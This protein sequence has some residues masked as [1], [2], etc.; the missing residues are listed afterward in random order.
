M[1]FVWI[2]LF[3]VLFLSACHS[4]VPDGTAD[5]QSGEENVQSSTF[6]S[7][8]KEAVAHKTVEE[9]SAFLEE[10]LKGFDHNYVWKVMD[11]YYDEVSKKSYPCKWIFA[12]NDLGEWVDIV[13][14]QESEEIA[15]NICFGE[16]Y[17]GPCIS[18]WR[19]NEQMTYN[20]KLRFP[21]YYVGGEAE[22]YESTNHE[23]YAVITGQMF[24]MHDFNNG[25]SSFYWDGQ[26]KTMG[27]RPNPTEMPS[28]PIEEDGY[29]TYTPA[30]SVDDEA[31]AI[32][33]RL[34]T[35][36]KDYEY[37]IKES[38]E[39]EGKS[40]PV[41]WIYAI[42]NDGEWVD[43]V[44]SDDSNFPYIF[45]QHSD[46]FWD[47]RQDVI[48][49]YNEKHSGRETKGV[50]TNN[51]VLEDVFYNGYGF[52]MEGNGLAMLDSGSVWQM[53]E[54]NDELGRFT[55]YF[56]R[57]KIWELNVIPEF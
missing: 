33:N 37:E 36:E 14:I 31:E 11:S 54:W 53:F 52:Y 34:S 13:L 8:I 4:A 30:K 27:A 26:W 42:N 40:Y 44:L 22:I 43:I 39:I 6:T 1:F 16:E 18:D 38:I 46:Y 9:A 25:S 55:L 56:S 15:N 23:Y 51:W 49:A 50:N 57:N 5:V 35:S 41:T 2:L 12:Y 10:K 28:S 7:I 19:K 20:H 29:D 47:L 24:A 45:R 17:T 48:T 3:S 21:F 32:K